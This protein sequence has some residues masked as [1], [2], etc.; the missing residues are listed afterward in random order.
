MVPLARIR[1]ISINFQE[2]GNGET[3]QERREIFKGIRTF[4]ELGEIKL[5]YCSF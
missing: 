3:V 2:V 4:L 1:R 5:S